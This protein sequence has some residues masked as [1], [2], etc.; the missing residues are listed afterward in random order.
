MKTAWTGLVEAGEVEVGLEGADLAAERVA[1]GDDVH[2][3]EVVAVEHDQSSTGAENRDAGAHDLAQR[4]GQ[5]LARDPERH[6]RRLAA[7]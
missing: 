2:Q 1:A 7:G 6:G 5:S 4:P 3:P